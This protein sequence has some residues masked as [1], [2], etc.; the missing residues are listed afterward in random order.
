M[1]NKQAKVTRNQIFSHPIRKLSA[2]ELEKVVA[3]GGF[4]LPSAGKTGGGQDNQGQQ[5]FR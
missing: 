4:E 5:G 1:K 2:D 3:G